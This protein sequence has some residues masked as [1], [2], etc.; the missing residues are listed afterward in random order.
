MTVPKHLKYT[1]DH[2][3]IVKEG[4]VYS[5][6]ITQFAQEELGEIVF[7][8]LPK[9]GKIYKKGDVFCVVEST[10]AASDVYAPV[11]CTIE[12]VNDELSDMPTTINESPYEKGWITKV[13]LEDEAD[14]N[15]LMVAE[16]YEKLISK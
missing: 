10:K 3:W 1:K 6:G 5:I 8:E 15:G 9:K 11:S 2:E 4:T 12:A 14:L 16:D 13:I 7:I